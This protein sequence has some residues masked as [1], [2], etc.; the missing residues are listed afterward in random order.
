MM[1]NHQTSI[2]RSAMNRI[3]LM[4]EIHADIAR[5]EGKDD[6]LSFNKVE[7]MK[8]I[9]LKL[10]VSRTS[11]FFGCSYAMAKAEALFVE[12]ETGSK[13]ELEFKGVIT[14]SDDVVEV[15]YELITKDDDEPVDV[16]EAI[17]VLIKKDGDELIVSLL[18]GV[19]SAN[20][21]RTKVMLT[22]FLDEKP[23]SYTRMKEIANAAYK[24]DGDKGITDKFLKHFINGK[25][26]GNGLLTWSGFAKDAIEWLV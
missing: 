10:G 3:E 17:D 7:A 2:G 12:E 25:L 20:L 11:D 16:V 14:G 23:T 4:K 21:K 24:E 15:V 18:K 6:F 1:I 5:M 26:I 13:D 8:E 9:D 22:G 19:K